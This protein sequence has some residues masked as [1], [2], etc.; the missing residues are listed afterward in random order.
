MDAQ[1]LFSFCYYLTIFV[2]NTSTLN[3]LRLTCNSP[4]YLKI[5]R[6]L[7][8]IFILSFG[9]VFHVQAQSNQTVLNGSFTAPA[10]FPS[11]TCGYTWTNSAPGIGLP[12]SGSGDIASFKAIN[13]GTTPIIATITATPVGAALAY[14]ANS[15]SNDVSVVSTGT[16]TVVATIPVGRNPFGAAV[17]PDGRSVYI[18]NKDDASVSVIDVYTNTV[19]ATITVNAG[20]QGIAA[21]PDG[22]YLYVACGAAN[23][24]AVINL[25][26]KTIIASISV[27]QNPYGVILNPSGTRAYVTNYNG[28]SVS[29]IGTSFYGVISTIATGDNPAG[30]VTS[31]DGKILYV[32]TAGA[33][34]MTEINAV[35]NSIIKEFTVR[36]NP[37]TIV[38][39]NAANELYLAGPTGVM[40][41]IKLNYDTVFDTAS[42]GATGMAF[43]PDHSYFYYTDKFN[44][45]L[46]YTAA[47]L[48]NGGIIS[49]LGN[50]PTS[51]G[52]F[53]APGPPCNLPIITFTIQ[54]DPSPNIQVSAVT[55][56][57]SSCMGTASSNPNIEQFTVSGSSLNTDI[58]I[59]APADFEISL[60]ENSGYTHNISLPAAAR[61][62]ARTTIFVRSSATASSGPLTGNINC[63]STGAADKQ[64]TVSGTVNPI[65]VINTISDQ[66]V[67]AGT[68]TTAVNFTGTAMRYSWVNSTPGIGLASS[69]NG[70]INSFTAINTTH[71]P[72]TA[73]ITVTPS[74]A[75]CTG[76]VKTFNITVDPAP[77]I[78]AN[79]NLKPATIEFGESSPVDNFTISGTNLS[80]GITVTAPVGFEIS[81]DNVTFTSTTTIGTAGDIGPST[82]YYRLKLGSAA[83]TYTGNILL[84]SP[85]AVNVSITL[86]NI[87]VIP[88]PLTVTADDVTKVYGDIL[89]SNSNSTAFKITAGSLKNGNTLTLV[90]INYGT[91]AASDA[92]VGSYPT[93]SPVISIGGNGFVPNNYKVNLVN[94]TITVSPATLTITADNKSKIFNAPIPQLTMHYGGFVNNETSAV[95]TVKPTISTNATMTSSVGNYLI[96]VTGATA[97]NYNIIYVDGVLTIV[98]APPT[99]TPPNAFTP[100]NDG[101][102]D[103]WE[104]PALAAY[105]DCTVKIYSRWGKLVFQSAGYSKPWDGRFNNTLLTEGTYYYVINPGNNQKIVSGV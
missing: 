84:T 96:T 3:P 46:S 64:V 100:N 32:A 38:I 73:T 58:N 105:P 83:D 62:V 7:V 60:N 22:N 17:S 54:V 61:T 51:F 65:P 18:T 67:S 6:N 50:G 14:V 68:L 47:S 25:A 75:T 88:A 15:G 52:N 41:I 90:A 53:I 33:N 45:R 101:I 86:P 28:R 56:S 12:A 78:T 27:G 95:I 97:K 4:V 70:P 74:S 8:A 5:S 57:I 94:G 1:P 2:L 69:G 85:A 29:V 34:K 19:T 13:T 81:S 11:G 42:P 36:A 66:T 30:M 79:A 43:T 9:L 24:V 31:S 40:N 44:N 98:P 39:N 71:G 35:N 49:P 72:I 102:N 21:S 82:I 10:V 91:G 76:E 55:G 37:T 103:L 26:S 99:I 59:A 48:G 92:A 77:V 63:T 89:K 23:R 20:P 87:V 16:K 80:A 93:I 104:I